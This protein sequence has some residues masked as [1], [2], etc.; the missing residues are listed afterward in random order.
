MQAFALRLYR[1]LRR[2]LEHWPEQRSLTP[3]VNLWVAYIA[4]WQLPPGTRGDSAS[5]GAAAPGDKP[6]GSGA[7]VAHPPQH[8]ILHAMLVI[9]IIHIRAVDMPLALSLNI[10]ISYKQTNERSISHCS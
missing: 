6:A 8:S 3:I 9:G 7:Q 5:G 10:C 4:P 1:L 2:A